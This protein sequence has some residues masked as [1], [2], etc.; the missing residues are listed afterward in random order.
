M[1]VKN[2]SKQYLFKILKPDLTTCYAL[3]HHLWRVLLLPYDVSIQLQKT[4]YHH[5]GDVAMKLDSG[6]N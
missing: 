3:M 6:S 1:P 5:A 2:L 4:I